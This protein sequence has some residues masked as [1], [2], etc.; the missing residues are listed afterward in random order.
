MKLVCHV[1]TKFSHDSML[2]FWLLYSC[3]LYHG[4][5]HITIT[6]HNNIDGA[7]AFKKYCEKKGNKVYVILGEEIMTTHGE[8][9]GLF[10]NNNIKAGLSPKETIFEIK[11]QGGIVYIPHPYDEKRYK[12]VLDECYI[13]EF[14]DSIDCI[15]VHNGRN[16]DIK[17]DKKQNEIADKYNLRKVIGGDIHT[18]IEIGKD[19]IESDINPETPTKF[20]KAIEQSHFICS[21]VVPIA[22]KFTVIDRLLSFIQR[23]D[24]NGL[25][26]TIVTRLK[27]NKL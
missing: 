16:I 23:R 20:I 25:Y 10:L 4:I 7:I 21:P 1:H 9:I 6:E 19:Y 24:F 3:C 14:K 22:H 8:I 26:R 2:P 17:Y 5:T 27:K 18:W 11:K 15:E 12:T 13:Q